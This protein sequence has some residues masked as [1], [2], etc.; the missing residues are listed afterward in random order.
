MVLRP[1]PSNRSASSVLHTRPPP[2]DTCH[3]HGQH[4]H[5]HVFSRLSMSQVS[6]TAA[7]HPGSG[8]LGPSLTSVLHPSGPS[9]RHVLLDLHLAI[10][11]RLRAP[12]LHNT[13]QETCTHS[14]RHGRVS[15]HST[16]FVDQINNHSSQN[17]HTKV[18]TTLCS[19][20]CTRCMPSLLPARAEVHHAPVEQ[21]RGSMG[22]SRE[23]AHHCISCKDNRK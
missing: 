23:R 5:S 17:E 7:S 13:S 20:S 3:L 9:A 2:F 22:N 21:G 8:S 15:H 14:F 18:L 6:A 10:G 4:G 11:Y 19:H 12:H 1:K 16:Y